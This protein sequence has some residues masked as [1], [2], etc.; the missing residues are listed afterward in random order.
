MDLGCYF[1]INSSAGS[2]AL[3]DTVPADRVLPETDHPFGDRRSRAAAHPGN[4]VD[5]ETRFARRIDTDL[6]AARLQVW[7]NL[8]A[9]ARATD[10]VG[11]FPRAAQRQFAAL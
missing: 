11:L 9:L 7:R 4:V 5:V 6:I 10:T 3:L 1:S 2:L 8:L